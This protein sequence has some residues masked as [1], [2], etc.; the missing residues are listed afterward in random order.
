MHLSLIRSPAINGGLGFRHRH[1]TSVW[2]KRIPAGLCPNLSLPAPQTGIQ[3]QQQP[4]RSRTRVKVSETVGAP[5]L[6]V[7]GA[8]SMGVQIAPERGGIG[9]RVFIDYRLP[10]GP[11]T[12]WL[13]W[14]FSGFYARWCVDQM[15]SG[16]VKQLVPRAAAA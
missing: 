4:S 9:L 13:G 2:H 8:Y 12:Y 1:A 16:V 5:S 3:S 15:P 11:E 7:I 14:L 10:D 6:L